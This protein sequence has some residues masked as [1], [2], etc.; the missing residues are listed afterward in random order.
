MEE[1]KVTLP[2]I[3]QATVTSE[4]NIALTKQQIFIQ[5]IQNEINSME[6]NEDN[7]QKMADLIKTI[8]GAEKLVTEAH[9]NGKEKYLKIC[10]IYDAVKRDTLSNLTGLKNQ[11]SVKYSELCAIIDKRKQEAEREKKRIADIKS[12]IENNLISFST[13]ISSCK[14]NEEL[15]SIERLINLEKSESRQQ[16][17]GEFHQEAIERYDTILMPIIKSQKEKVKEFASLTNELSSAENNDDVEKIDELRLK[18]EQLENEILQNQVKV[19]EE[20]ISGPVTLGITIAEEIIPDVNSVKRIK[21]EFQ[22]VLTAVKRCP[23]LLNIEINHRAAQKLAMT[24]KEAGTFD[25]K[26]EAIV[27][28]IRF[29]VEKTYKP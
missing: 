25:K 8:N 9:K 19:Q 14:T 21:F 22:D 13:K 10:G 16:K 1:N 24:L 2:V 15:L 3:T 12:G 27:N 4:M 29:F 5:N 26:D 11:I 20:A 17:Y 18:Q 7:L 28:G 6:W 23:E